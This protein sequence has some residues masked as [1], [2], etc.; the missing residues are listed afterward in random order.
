MSPEYFAR[1]LTV[2]EAQAYLKGLQRRQHPAWETARYVAFYAAKPHCKETFTFDSMGLFA[3][4]KERAAA[5]A[6]DEEEVRALREFARMEDEENLKRI[7][8]WQKQEK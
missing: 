2:Y 7:K 4:E 3:W 1:T 8:Q 5:V 6:D